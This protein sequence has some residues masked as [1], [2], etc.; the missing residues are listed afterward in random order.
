MPIIDLFDPEKHVSD[1]VKAQR[2]ETCAG[3]QRRGQR[4]G[5]DICTL[6]T[7]FLDLKTRLKTEEC[8]LKKWAKE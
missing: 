6:C 1:Q 2:L 7:C 8:P 3:C 5:K 4:F